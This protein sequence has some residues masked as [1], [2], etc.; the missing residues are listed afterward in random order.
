MFRNLGTK[1]LHFLTIETISPAVVPS[2]RVGYQIDFKLSST[3]F[4]HVRKSG[5]I[6]G[7]LSD[8]G[9]FNDALCL[10]T[11]PLFAYVSAFSYS[12]S[13]TNDMPASV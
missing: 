6:L 12:L 4:V 11:K 9:G 13:V 5:T 1:V 10:L 7:W 2:H 8:I 3:K